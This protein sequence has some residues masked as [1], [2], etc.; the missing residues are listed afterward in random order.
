MLENTLPYVGCD[1]NPLQLDHCC[2][3]MY[4]L[5]VMQHI[6]YKNK[7]HFFIS[8]LSILYWIEKFV[9]VLIEF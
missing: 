3:Q 9:L 1:D 6:L 4:I 5:K 8:L 7:Q 2:R